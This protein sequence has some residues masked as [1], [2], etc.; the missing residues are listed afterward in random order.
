MLLLV[1]QPHDWTKD[2]VLLGWIAVASLVVGVIGII[3][4]I[5]AGY[6]FYHKGK[7]RKQ[8]MY[9]VS[10]D[11]RIMSIPGSTK[12]GSIKVMYI[13]EDGHA[14]EVE[15]GRLVTLWIRNSGNVD[16]KVWDWQ[17]KDGEG[18]EEPIQ[19]E[20]EQRKLLALTQVQTTPRE[21][22][23]SGDNLHAYLSSPFASTECLGLPLCLLKPN[24]SLRLGVLLDGPKTAVKVKGRFVDGEV[25]SNVD[26]YERSRWWRLVFLPFLTFLCMLMSVVILHGSES[27]GWWLV[28]S[29][30]VSVII[31]V[32][33]MLYE[34]LLRPTGT[35]KEAES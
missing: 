18:L 27:I 19:F 9:G 24:H 29:V 6:W 16:V 12:K 30:F 15:R 2:P 28:A 8:I 11:A 13:D 7:S 3:I 25:L 35:A 4:G 10:S 20:F 32:V 31:A 17:H 14:K 34:F 22:V 1:V 23:V 5:V 21:G 33:T 26:L